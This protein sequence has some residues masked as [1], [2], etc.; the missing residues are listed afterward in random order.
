[1]TISELIT[2]QILVTYREIV[3]SSDID[4]QKKIEQEEELFEAILAG[5]EGIIGKLIVI[6]NFKN[7]DI[8]E[9]RRVLYGEMPK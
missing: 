2:K 1:M 4:T 5:E 7:K 6:K 3:N 9:V 8:A